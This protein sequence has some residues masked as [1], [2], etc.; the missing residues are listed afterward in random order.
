MWLAG[1]SCLFEIL[2]FFILCRWLLLLAFC[3]FGCLARWVSDKNNKRVNERRQNKINFW[4]LFIIIIFFVS[5]P[6]CFSEP[7]PRC[8]PMKSYSRASSSFTLK[9][10]K[11][12]YENDYGPVDWFSR[13]RVLVSFFILFLFLLHR[14]EADLRFRISFWGMFDDFDLQIKIVGSWVRFWFLSCCY[15]SSI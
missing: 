12:Y 6:L 2:F 1:F 11:I 14:T 4:F 7:F 8:S 9:M 13:L 5:S 15:I 3:C 10:K